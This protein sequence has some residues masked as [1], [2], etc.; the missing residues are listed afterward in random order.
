MQFDSRGVY[1]FDGRVRCPMAGVGSRG[2]YA[3]NRLALDNADST[4][5]LDR[6]AGRITVDNR[7]SYAD[8]AVIADLAFLAEGVHPGGDRSPFAIHLKIFKTGD[9]VSV[10]LHRHLRSQAEMVDVEVE[11]FEVIVTGGRRQQ[12]VL[13]Q[14]AIDRLC[15]KPGLALRLVK[16]LMAMR[17]NLEGVRQ[18]PET[19]GFKVADLS[20]GFGTRRLAWMMCRAELVSL[21]ADN[22][23]LIRG[24][25]VTEMLRDGAW[26]LKLSIHT[27]RYLP[28]VVK[29]DLFLFGLDEQPLLAGARERGLRKGQTMSFRFERGQGALGVDG[30]IEPMAGALDVARDY[31]E[32]HMLGG[33]L[34]EEAEKVAARYRE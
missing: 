17:D 21:S 33:L 24:A 29:R 15:K 20:L 13:D 5:T 3:S 34:A 2:E 18:D 6:E 16:S 19:P 30:E 4:V 8:K 25:P 7:V 1:F 31:I 27:D 12:V 28:D 10:D 23:E 9:K 14:K 26:E 11:P 32:F 22:A